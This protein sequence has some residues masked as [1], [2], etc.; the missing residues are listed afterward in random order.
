MAK[1]FENYSRLTGKKN[2]K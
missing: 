2:T 1:R